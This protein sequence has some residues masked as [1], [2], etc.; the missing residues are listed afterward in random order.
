MQSFK[1]IFYFVFDFL[2]LRIFLNKKKSMVINFSYEWR[3]LIVEKDWFNNTSFERFTFR[4][5]ALSHQTRKLW[6]YGLLNIELKQDVYITWIISR[7]NE[8]TKWTL[9]LVHFPFFISLPHFLLLSLSLS[10]SLGLSSSR[11]L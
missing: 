10:L 8:N 9:K 2:F 7:L 5:R 3:V 1:Y 4:V 6:F 11:L